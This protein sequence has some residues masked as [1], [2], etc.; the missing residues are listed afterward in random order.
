[1]IILS[2]GIRLIYIYLTS[3]NSAKIG[4]YLSKR[5]YSTLLNKSYLDHVSQSSSYVIQMVSNNISRTVGIIS[6]CGLIISSLL[7]TIA[8]LYT[9]II[10]E[11]FITIIS[12]FILIFS[13][14]L[15]YITSRGGLYLNGK[16]VKINEEKIIRLVKESLDKRV[17][18]LEDSIHSEDK[19]SY[20]TSFP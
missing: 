12:L 6:S 10:T 2:S 11:P 13:Y 18:I 3:I 17:L 8:I 7:V 1:M 14:F 9:L 15:I 19:S 16:I 4:T 5:V 20:K